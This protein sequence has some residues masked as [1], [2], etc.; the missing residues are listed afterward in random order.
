[1]IISCLQENLQRGLQFVSHVS[2]KEQHLPILST[3]LL[4]T[5]EGLITLHA[6]NLELGAS[7]SIRGKIEKEGSIA[8][9]AKIFTD[10]ISL[11][12]KEKITI[13]V[14]DDYTLHITCHT[15]STKILGMNP[16]E[17][18]LMPNIESPRTLEC[19]S[20]ALKK[21]LQQTLFTVS[22]NES[23]QEL[24]GVLF[25]LTPQLKKLTLV[26]TDAYRLAETTLIL[27]SAPDEDDAFIM[28]LRSAQEIARTLGVDVSGKAQ[29]E[30]N[31]HQISFSCDTYHLISKRI[32]GTYPDYTQIIPQ[33]F[34]TKIVLSVYECIKATKT[35]S[36][37]SK[38]TLSDIHIKCLTTNRDQGRILLSSSNATCG[39]SNVQLECE[40]RGDE[41]DITLNYHYFLDGLQALESKKALLTIIDNAN[42]CILK[43]FEGEGY[44]YLIMPIRQ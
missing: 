9:P 37:F 3:I 15:Y 4:K 38:S 12:P 20:A 25:S 6:T 31:D 43:P 23:K 32:Q 26:G 33:S 10:Y 44:Q 13:E 29:I 42:P 41:N 2:N 35:T 16:D 36:L 24:S 19:Q 1:V 21:S 39:E 34:T 7:C 28:P 11:L 14:H 8:V 22:A 40:V 18:P 27:E 17:F 30:W 5:H